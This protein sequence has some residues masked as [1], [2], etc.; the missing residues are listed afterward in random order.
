MATAAPPVLSTR[1][2]NRALLA[3]QMLLERSR[4]PVAGAVAHLVGL[5]A[6]TPRSP[7]LALWSRLADFDPEALSRLMERRRAARIV[8]MRSTIHLVTADDL[9]FLRPL[10]APYLARGLA[11]STWRLGLDGLDL[12]E[13]AAAGRAL[14]E[15]EPLGFSALGA[16]LAERWPGRDPAT[17]AQVARAH[18]PLVQVPPR[19]LWGRSGAVTVTSAE[20]WLGRP[21]DAGARLDDLV[22]RYLAAFGPAS[23]LDVQAWCG[24]TGLG[25]VVDRLGDRLRRFG[26]ED[27]RALYDLPRA[28][29]P[30]PDVPAPVRFLPDFDN[31]TLSHADRTRVI[32]D[33]VRRALGVRDRVIP[34]SVLVDGRVE[35]AWHRDGGAL[36]V[37]PLRRL[38]ARERDAVEA[39]GLALLGLLDPGGDGAEV[40]V[41]APA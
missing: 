31:L 32:D 35:A 4:R 1:A 2:L 33:E 34:G 10:M 17:L 40:R 18:V 29:R 23:V 13:V 14:V 7:Y 5:Q 30:D 24:L 37:R 3:R 28:P 6:Q 26:N 39:E 8:L 27:G 22:L 36:E 9:V 20:R 41:R 25:E 38:S 21:L 19:G 16:R 12:D 15:A 11:T